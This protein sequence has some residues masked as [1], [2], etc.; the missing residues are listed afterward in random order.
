V[1]EIIQNNKWRDVKLVLLM[2]YG[3]I[4]GMQSAIQKLTDRERSRCHWLRFFMVLGFL[5]PIIALLLYFVHITNTFALKDAERSTADSTGVKRGPLPFPVGVDADEK[6]IAELPHIEEFLSKELSR[7]TEVGNDAIP[8]SFL[9]KAVAK[10][11]L[12]DWYQ[13][14]ASAGATRVLVIQPG[15]RKEQIAMNFAKILKWDEETK[16]EFLVTVVSSD[17]VLLEGTFAPGTYMVTSDAR[18][19]DIAPLISNRFNDEIVSR[20]PKDVAAKVPLSDALTVASLIEREAYDFEDMRYIAGVIWNRLFIDMNL[21]ID[22]TLQYAKG[23]KA[24]KT[25]WPKPVPNDKYIDSPYN[26]YQNSGLP[27]TPIANPSVDAILAALN[28]RETECMYYFHDKDS[29]FHCSKTYEEHVVLLKEY[30][31]RGK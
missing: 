27:P 7:T 12:L 31:G 4:S 8:V 22:S 28:P 5:L 11:A 30:Y 25:W 16:R 9:R 26:T 2:F 6:T 3:I 29:K 14:L 19:A 17:P 15:E 1:G 23:T 13:S 21:Q 18:P 20:Y 24:P 10:L